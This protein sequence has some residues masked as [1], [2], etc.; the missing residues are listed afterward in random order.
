MTENFESI[1]LIALL[2]TLIVFFGFFIFSGSSKN[3][4]RLKIL[5]E[6]QDNLQKNIIEIIENNIMKIDSKVEKSSLEQ[7]S[8]LNFI[9]EKI[10]LIDRAQENISNLSENVL[11]LKNILSNTSKRG[12]FGEM[13]L[14]NL[15]KDQLPSNNFEFQKTLSNNT[16][17]DCIIKSPGPLGKL[18][19]DAKFPREGY[20]KILNSKTKSEKD[21]SIKIFKNDI[22]KH[23]NDVSDKYIIPGETS[24]IALI[25]IPSESIYLEIFK[26]FPEI[27]RTFYEKKS[28]LISPTTLWVILSSIESMLRDRKIKENAGLI[29]SQLQQLSNELI[30]LETRVKK[31]DSHF[32]GAQKDLD[33]VITTTKKITGKTKKIL[34]ISL[35]E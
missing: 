8:N 19:I 34:G 35:K 14:E 32:S 1:I 27:S 11:N 10:S 4:E 26:F 18:C 9:R 6:R 17:V 23:I 7:T 3:K 28:F 13:M 15:V 5:L 16:R 33:D 30:R 22:L 12:R 31:L 20:E 24:E 21:T 25:F 29:Q 2:I